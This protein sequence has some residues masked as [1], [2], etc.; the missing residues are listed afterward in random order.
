MTEKQMEWSRKRNE[1][2]SAIKDLGFPGEL[3]EQIAKQLGSPK[4]IDRML[5]YLYNVKPGTAELVVDEMLAICSDIDRWHDK[6][7]AEEANAKY[8][9]ML[10]EGLGDSED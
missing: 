8:N 3:G 4:A 2:V 9:Q 5:A 7:A 6:K 1:L 10:Y